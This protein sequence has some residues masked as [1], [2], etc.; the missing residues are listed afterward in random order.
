MKRLINRLS[1]LFVYDLVFEHYDKYFWSRRYNRN[2]GKYVKKNFFLFFYLCN[3][4]FTFVLRPNKNTFTLSAD[5]VWDNQAKT[6]EEVKGYV[7]S[8]VNQKNE[9]LKYAPDGYTPTITIFQI[10]V[11][12][13]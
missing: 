11:F 7:S 1:K 10:K 8:Y 5:L 3:L 6:S 4:K 2:L 9:I 13:K 12:C